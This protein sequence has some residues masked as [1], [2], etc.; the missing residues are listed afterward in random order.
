[1]ANE[2]GKLM[3]YLYSVTTTN[4]NEVSPSWV[5]RYSDALSAVEVYQKFIDYGFANEYRTVNLSEPSGKMHTK[6]FYRN[7]NVGGK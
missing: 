2:R 3:E 1:M 5:G 4:D 6:V 7:G